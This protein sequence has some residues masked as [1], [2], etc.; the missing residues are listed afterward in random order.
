MRLLKLLKLLAPVGL[1]VVVLGTNPD[2]SNGQFP[3]GDRGSRGGFPGG[4]FPGGD[5]GSRDRGD[6]GSR[7]S[8]GG[9]NSSSMA[10][11]SFARLQASYGGSGDTLDYARI[12]QATRDQSNAMAQRFGAEPLPTSGSITKDQY[13]DQ[14]AKRMEA[15]RGGRGGM[16]MGF[17]APG[18]TPGAPTGVVTFGA[19]G[20]TPTP[21]APPTWGGAPPG[22]YGQPPGGAPQ[23]VSDDQIKEYMKRY[24]RDNDGRISLEE[25]SRSDR[26]RGVFQQY[27][28]NTDG[29]LD[30]EEYKGYVN[31][32]FSG[33][34][35]NSPPGSPPP[36]QQPYGYGQPP[37]GWG[38][39]EGGQ[40][41]Q[42]QEEPKPV[43]WRYGKL[44]KDLPSWFTSMD[45]NQ[46]GQIALYEWR[47]EGEST[48]KFVPMDLNGD[49]LVTAE[50]YL[51]FKNPSGS[52]STET[53]S[54]SRDGSSSSG[55]SR[56]SSSGG[57]SSS[58]RSGGFSFG[59]RGGSS[60]GGDSRS[61]SDRGSRGSDRGSRPSGVNPFGRR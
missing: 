22:S 10:D 36:G 60:T 14:M 58:S 11:S 39:P 32:R 59:S 26:L 31:D 48:E 28:R 40:P 55:S 20:S 21:G 47:N 56:G 19:P 34:D 42:P 13:R 35:S 1:A 8:F 17:T 53:S 49:G 18:S 2:Q 4:G 9:F 41:Q 61:S 5:R 51:R 33:R 54:S 45:T 37:G 43:V 29:F 30:M 15:M 16:T 38:G 46:D 3:G 27:D 50:E 52:I 7:G 44:P 6:R 24:D 12:P 57:S 25:G 23:Q